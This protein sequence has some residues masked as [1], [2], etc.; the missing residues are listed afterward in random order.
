MDSDIDRSHRSGNPKKKKKE[1][2]IIGKF[3]WFNQRNNIF[4]N[5]QLLEGKKFQSRK[6]R[7]EKLSKP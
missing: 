7:M 6:S 3:I 1:R 2:P 5:K 4:K